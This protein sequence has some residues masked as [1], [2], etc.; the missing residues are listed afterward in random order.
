MKSHQILAASLAAIMAPCL[1]A[2]SAQA[3]AYQ[4]GLAHYKS[5]AEEQYAVLAEQL[6]L[7]MTPVLAEAHALQHNEPTRSGV[8]L[9]M[10]TRLTLARTGAKSTMILLR[11]IVH[12]VR[13]A[14]S[15]APTGSLKRTGTLQMRGIR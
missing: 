12:F 5:W 1:F 11:A 4:D 15:S 10:T 7:G 14:V 6:S 8:G 3:S 13:V 2:Q 9:E